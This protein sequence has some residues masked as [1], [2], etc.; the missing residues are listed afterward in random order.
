[1]GYQ[2]ATTT[3]AR[4]AIAIGVFAG[5]VSQGQNSIAIGIQ[6]GRGTTTGLGTNSIAIG[7][8][9]GVASQVANSICL[10]ASGSGLNPANAGCYIRPIRGDALGIGAG[11][12]FYDTTNFELVYSTT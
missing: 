8:S 4:D 6:A 11:L 1:L 12:V 5:E 2:A 7:N 9:A 3:P 10:N